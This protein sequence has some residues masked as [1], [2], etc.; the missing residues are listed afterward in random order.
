MKVGSVRSLLTSQSGREMQS[1]RQPVAR[2]TRSSIF[3][4]VWPHSQSP[5]FCFLQRS[6][7]ASINRER[8]R[9]DLPKQQAKLDFSQRW[10]QSVAWIESAH[11]SLDQ[12]IQTAE[13][14]KDRLP[15]PHPTTV[16]SETDIIHQIQRMVHHQYLPREG[17]ERRWQNETTRS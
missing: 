4:Q 11:V 10:D 8:S 1:R 17:C 5:A 7:E 13:S 3:F 15:T 14:I 12:I 2:Y 6:R 9:I 16:R